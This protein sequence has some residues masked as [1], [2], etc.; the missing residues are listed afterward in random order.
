MYMYIYINIYIY[1][2]IYIHIYIYTYQKQDRSLCKATEIC[3]FIYIILFLP[4]AHSLILMKI[5]CLC[6]LYRSI[7]FDFV[8]F[9]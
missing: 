1:I 2:Y 9:W 3:A 8:R 7:V 4:R 5:F 6:G